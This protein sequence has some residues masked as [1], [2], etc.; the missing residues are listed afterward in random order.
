MVDINLLGEESRKEPTQQQDS[1]FG[2]AMNT[3]SPDFS[4]ER[5]TY[6]ADYPGLGVSRSNTRLYLIL[7]ALAVVALL[8]VFILMRGGNDNESTAALNEPLQS[9]D[10]IQQS[11][12]AGT[13]LGESAATGTEGEPGAASTAGAQ[14]VQ[15]MNEPS[16][17]M[18]SPAEKKMMA[19][20]RLGSHVVNSV[21]NSM[22]NGANLTLIRFAENSFLAEFVAPTDDDMNSVVAAIRR[23]AMPEGLRIISRENYPIHGPSAV[24][25]LVSGS[26]SPESSPVSLNGSIQDMSVD[27]LISW[28]RSTAGSRGLRI[29]TLNQSAA[30]MAG[31]YEVTP[32]QIMLSGDVSSALAF[33]QDLSDSVPNVAIEKISLINNDPRANSDDSVSL[34][35]VLQQY[36]S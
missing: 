31:S 11:P 7:G 34:V 28:V 25:V 21:A 33:L 36:A 2:P 14:D 30:S 26:I 5:R 1:G 8:I 6:N 18:L 4:T 16:F 19:S 20:I 13:G 9:K 17:D 32:V 29:K 3:P 23:N 10:L 24:K 12:S 35:L 27:G 22:V 15:E